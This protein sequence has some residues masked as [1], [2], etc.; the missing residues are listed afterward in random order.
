MKESQTDSELTLESL[1]G[2]K[3]FAQLDVDLLNAKYDRCYIDITRPKKNVH[4]VLI[5]IARYLLYPDV[6]IPPV[7]A[8][9]L[10]INVRNIPGTLSERGFVQIYAPMPSLR[11]PGTGWQVNSG[12]SFGDCIR[13]AL[14]KKVS[15]PYSLRG[16]ILRPQLLLYYNG[17]PPYMESFPC[18]CDVESMKLLWEKKFTDV[19]VL[20]ARRS[21]I[22][23]HA[24]V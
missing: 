8:S 15:R 21:T 3:G 10:L 11:D 14:D 20:D 13:E 6:Q 17:D 22:V 24:V 23:V 4:T 7:G 1:V 5:A 19:W 12:G 18:E 2:T 9:T 16:K